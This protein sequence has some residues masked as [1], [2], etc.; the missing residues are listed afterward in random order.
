[1]EKIALLRKQAEEAGRD[2]NS[3]LV[4]LCVFGR[5]DEALVSRMEEAGV[6]RLILN[7]PSEER[8][9]TLPILDQYA[10]LIS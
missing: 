1:M 4:S 5:A 7:L 10:A 9:K 3:I 8:D 2:P 6:N